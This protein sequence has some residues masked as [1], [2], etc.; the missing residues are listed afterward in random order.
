MLE[1]IG[2]WPDKMVGY[3]YPVKDIKE[4]CPTFTAVKTPHLS[5]QGKL[6]CDFSASTDS[7]NNR[8]THWGF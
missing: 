6:Q 7:Q 4:L 1:T 3:Y 5:F 2:D 8:C